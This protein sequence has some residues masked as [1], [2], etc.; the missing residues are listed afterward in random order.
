MSMVLNIYP[1]DRFIAGAAIVVVAISI[2]TAL[3]LLIAKLLERRPTARHTVLASALICSLATPVIALLIRTS[4]T[5]TFAWN[6]LPASQS[7]GAE[8]ADDA[9][10]TA[11]DPWP[12]SL[13]AS[14]EGKVP[15]LPS[16]ESTSTGASDRQESLQQEGAAASIAAKN[17]ASLAGVADSGE[18]IRYGLTL[19]MIVWLVGCG[20][21][22]IQLLCGSARVWS[23]RRTGRPLLGDSL[24]TVGRQVLRSLGTERLPEILVSD[25]VQS[26]VAAGPLRGAVILPAELVLRMNTEELC[27]V[28]IHECAHV[29][30]R[31]PLTLHLQ[32]VAGLVFWPIPLV[33]WLNRQLCS[34]REEICDN[35]V[36]A[37]RDA[38]QYAE[39]LLRIATL[40]GEMRR[41]FALIGMLH[42][43][44]EL[45]SRIAGLIDENRNKAT[46]AG[47]SRSAL[48]LSAFLLASVAVCG[49]T[50]QG[51]RSD[52]SPPRTERDS[53]AD[54]AA[55][56]TDATKPTQ[57]E[58]WWGIGGSIGQAFEQQVDQFN[59]SQQRI[60]V[61]IR[62]LDGY[63]GVHRKLERAF[64]GDSLPDAAIVEIHHVASIAADDQIEPLDRFVEEDPA[65]KPGDLLPG[66]LANLRYHDR[67]YALPMNR[68]TP[69]LYYNKDRFAA[70]GLDPARPPAT[71]E[72]VREMSR[73]LT[74][75]DQ[76]QYGFVVIS[77]PWIF[78]S[79]VWSNGGKLIVDG[80]P[81]F[82]KAG[83][84]PLQL[85][86]DMVH[87]DHT[88]DFR[89]RFDW[90]AEFTSGR[91]AMAV[92]STA[93]L[94]SILSQSNFE[95]G[96]A[97]L[98]RSEGGENAV[99]TG[100]GA[101]V[102]PAAIS[103][104]RKAAAWTFL[105]WFINTQ[106]AAQW[107]RGTGYIPVRESA[108]TLLQTD[109]FYDTHP[110]FKVAIEQMKY[111]R[112][113]P[114]LPRWGAVWKIIG[115]KMTSVVCDDAPALAALEGA[116]REAAKLLNPKAASTSSNKGA[117]VS[118][119]VGEAESATALALATGP[120][121]TGRATNES[122]EALADV[123]VKVAV[124]AK[125]M[126]FVFYGAGFKTLQ[127]R[128]DRDG[129]YR[130]ELPATVE[131]TASIDAMKPGYR[132][133]AGTLM[134]G[135]D[136]RKVDVSPGTVAQASFTLPRALYVK[137]VVVDELG[138]P[139]AGGRVFAHAGFAHASGGIEITESRAD[140]SFEVFNYP[141]EPMSGGEKFKGNI[142]FEH[143]D[144]I[145]ET[146]DDI[147]PMS[148]EQAHRFAW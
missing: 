6:L 115:D 77:F 17:P 102:I 130:L 73:A 137:G 134:N 109:G 68:S 63:A 103:A 87:R 39:T 126:R 18:T 69:V 135:G 113:A 84:G 21:L 72:E 34:A 32:L 82:A 35:Y 92:E 91:A 99:P 46:R 123:L 10:E 75:T 119:T 11:I 110:Q 45:E 133:L 104:E 9:A 74:S 79:M 66:I 30:R 52:A 108:R 90:F 71:W 1:G 145:A 129:R 139:I 85:W 136:A 26:P 19:A 122:G 127:A 3:S 101:A 120:V 48:C 13:L 53:L 7:D 20:L 8:P 81:A 140:G 25:R 15:A 148:A 93:L 124:P 117:E 86:A 57:I 146:I 143:P 40:V 132:S 31:D 47:R 27:A 114:Q 95:V 64:Q 36:L 38:L 112:E 89:G 88:A 61:K 97:F 78:E 24:E 23:I 12:A 54:D 22:L 111:A 60:V 43:R 16:I 37:Q 4:G 128:T 14:E 33:H 106:Q 125:D 55:P 56:A 29:V 96:T 144:Y 51:T 94:E 62:W 42:W 121:I 142:A 2:T 59:A 100:G 98:P 49:T 147:Y 138:A 80:A 58:V 5:S 118:R 41:P 131:A 105:T 65:F 141:L 28:L 116:E 67:L 50:I 107:S 76:Q 83:A 44:G 70:A